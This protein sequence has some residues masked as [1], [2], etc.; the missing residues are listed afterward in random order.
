MAID[1]W[2]FLLQVY[3]SFDCLL[4]VCKLIDTHAEANEYL[5]RCRAT[6]PAVYN[7]GKSGG[8]TTKQTQLLSAN[9]FN[10]AIN[11]NFTVVNNRFEVKAEKFCDEVAELRNRIVAHNTG[12][13]DG[14]DDS[15]IEFL[16][17][18]IDNDSADE[19]DEIVPQVVP[20]NVAANDTSVAADST[21][22]TAN[23]TDAS[24][25]QIATNEN[26]ANDMQ[27]DAFDDFSGDIP[28]ITN[29]VDDRYY[30]DYDV[31]LR[32]AV[33][34]C[35]TA[36]N[37]SNPFSTVIYDKRFIGVLLKEVFRDE[38]ALNDLNDK[39]MLFIKR[40]FEI[41]VDGDVSRAGKFESI[42]S[43]KHTKA[44]NRGRAN[45]IDED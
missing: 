37:K 2:I 42:V 15:D 29:D 1:F 40:V 20:A 17:D 23:E 5:D 11:T 38:L 28:F 34:K 24:T 30:N 4:F 16:Q 6:I 9:E 26:E 25:N 41:R 3:F 13:L 21:F 14:L 43:E 36:W 39:Q 44:Q 19:L 8:R 10:D 18:E 22:M 31:S 33:V 7:M 12:G 32:A 27:L 35:L 45:S